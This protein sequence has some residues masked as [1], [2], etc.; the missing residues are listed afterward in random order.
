MPSEVLFYRQGQRKQRRRL[1]ARRRKRRQRHQFIINAKL[2]PVSGCFAVCLGIPLPPCC[3]IFFI[4]QS[5]A[6]TSLED[7]IVP[8]HQESPL[9]HRQSFIHGGIA[10]LFH[11]MC[12]YVCAHDNVTRTFT[13]VE[14]NACNSISSL[15]FAG[16][17]AQDDEI[18]SMSR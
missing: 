1:K 15:L 7:I 9:L 5:A 14:G 10:L 3:T 17:E 11:F 2:K 13:V 6:L 12:V 8:C 18:G 16:M 4:L